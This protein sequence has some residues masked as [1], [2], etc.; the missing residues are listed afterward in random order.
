MI[1]KPWKLMSLYLYPSFVTRLFFNHGGRI[2]ISLREPL[3][4]EFGKKNLQF[5]L[6]QNNKKITFGTNLLF[7]KT[8]FGRNI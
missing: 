4:R 6:N 3:Y 1:I 2:D 8:M 5:K 7:F